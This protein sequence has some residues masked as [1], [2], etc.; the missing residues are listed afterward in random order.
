MSGSCASKN[1]GV[2]VCS[3]H[4]GARTQVQMQVQIL[5]CVQERDIL[6]GVQERDIMACVNERYILVG[7]QER[8]ILACVQERDILKIESRIH[9]IHAYRSAINL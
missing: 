4:V 6:V 3:G 7:V 8:D 1:T 9:G 5:A 2:D